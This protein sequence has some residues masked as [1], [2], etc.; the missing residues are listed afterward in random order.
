MLTALEDFHKKMLIFFQNKVTRIIQRDN[1]K[2]WAGNQFWKETLDLKT[3]E[4]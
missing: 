4:V 3:I 1:V 2:N